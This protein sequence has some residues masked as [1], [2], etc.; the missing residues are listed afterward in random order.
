MDELQ[1]SVLKAYKNDYWTRLFVL[2]DFRKD[3][4]DRY[5]LGPD[6]A[7]AVVELYRL[8]D[9]AMPEWKPIFDPQAFQQ[10]HP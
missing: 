9:N 2:D 5:E 3:Q 7:E 4:H 6:I 8:D 1:E 10:E